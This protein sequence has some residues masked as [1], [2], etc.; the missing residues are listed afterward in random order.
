MRVFLHCV[1]MC[2]ADMCDMCVVLA[3]LPEC[4]HAK[5][6][7][8]GV[9][10]ACDELCI[11]LAYAM[12]VFRCLCVHVR[13]CMFLA[14]RICAWMFVCAHVCENVYVCALVGKCVYMCV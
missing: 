5:A 3:C 13:C 2:R 4:G 11:A 12:C 10:D 8:C 9:H 7:V 1:N 14:H 6:F